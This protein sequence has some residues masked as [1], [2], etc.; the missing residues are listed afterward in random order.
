MQLLFPT[1]HLK[2]ERREEQ[3]Y[4][5]GIVRKKWYVLQP[6]ELVRQ[7]M[8]DWMIRE[9]GVSASLISVE[10]GIKYLKLQKRFDVVV[11]DNTGKAF[12]LCECKAPDVPL[13]QDTLNQIARYNVSIEAPHLLLTNG[14]ELLFFSQEEGKYVH[15]KGGW[16][17]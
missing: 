3:D 10:K 7:A 4:I 14:R 9:K 5:W 12:I 17:K 11:Y 15:K 6:E 1:Q 16:W 8:L 2:M 13:S